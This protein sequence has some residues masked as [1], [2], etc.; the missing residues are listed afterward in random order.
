M[1]ARACG[2]VSLEP[3]KVSKA[4]T[5]NFCPHDFDAYIYYVAN[6]SSFSERFQILQIAEILKDR[7]SWFRD[8]RSLEI[9]TMFPAGNGGTIELLCTQ[10]D[11]VIYHYYYVSIQVPI[12]E[13]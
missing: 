11:G 6:V 13:N 7:L 9:F 4:V 3:S 1:A 2:L 10:V 5:S 8:C 12:S